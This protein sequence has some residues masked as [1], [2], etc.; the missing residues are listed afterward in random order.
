[1]T[2]TLQDLLTTT[3]DA[4]AP[5]P[6][7]RTVASRA[8]HDPFAAFFKNATGDLSD[9][10][11]Q[12]SSPTASTA[13]QASSPSSNKT[14]TA[15]ADSAAS[16]RSN[17]S[18]DAKT[19]KTTAPHA[20]K[21][22]DAHNH[23]KTQK[24]AANS[25]STIDKTA[26]ANMPAVDAKAPNDT[27]QDAAN[28]QS[29]GTATPTNLFQVTL[30]ATQAYADTAAAQP[31]AAP[32]IVT[33]DATTMTTA[34]PDA[35]SNA[36]PVSA[37]LA[38]LLAN[39]NEAAAQAAAVFPGAQSSAP[40]QTGPS[41]AILQANPLGP[42]KTIASSTVS[43]QPRTADARNAKGDAMALAAGSAGA[44]SSNTGPA[45]PNKLVDQAKHSSTDAAPAAA[46]PMPPDPATLAA[47]A[48]ANIDNTPTAPATDDTDATDSGSAGP[49]PT[50]PATT[51]LASPQQAQ[52]LYNQTISRSDALPQITIDQVT[53]RLTKAAD[54]E[55]DH[56]TIHL[57]PAEL[58]TI[59][60]KLEMG[61]DG[62]SKAT[63]SADRQDT[64]NLL[65]KDS[66]R[67]EQ[68]L[69]S[70]GIKTDSGTLSFN[71]RGDGGNRQMQNFFQQQGG[72]YQPSTPSYA[73]SRS[74]ADASLPGAST[75]VGYLNT[76]A[77]L[78]G[79]DIRV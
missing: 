50:G 22:G 41:I 51:N 33:P 27:V 52:A 49:T 9:G 46:A 5:S 32:A 40:I 39:Q 12:N 8:Q 71:L 78:G 64:L 25:D 11:T 57:K 34:A 76:R 62:I 21:Q 1:M 16:D 19:G 73:S 54:E 47:T 60:V 77:A 48:F 13:P 61:D 30:L 3:T 18:N 14:D 79:V 66:H 6:A 55:L 75:V 63:I 10:I 43:T 26:A 44:E 20:T 15:D 23:R 28:T 36:Q 70:A 68:A 31:S 56:L 4:N 72:G 37:D 59:E 65:Q 29:T 58:G 38:T 69:E 17:G 24:Q 53:M 35:A 45:D 42:A 2:L 7:P 74:F 67:L